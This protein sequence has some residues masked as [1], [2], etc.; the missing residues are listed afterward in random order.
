FSLAV[1]RLVDFWSHIRP[2]DVFRTDARTLA[3]VGMKWAADLTLGGWIGRH[4][5][6]SLLRS[7]P[8]RAVLEERLDMEAVH[9][10]IE[11][12]F[13][14]GLA[15]TTT[16]YRTNLGVTFFE[17][18]PEIAPWTRSTRFGIRQRLT[19]EHVMASSAIPIFFPAIRI[20]QRYYA[21][22]CL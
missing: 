16:D 9:E 22:G 1:R 8:L 13:L 11:R 17:G 5:E 18:A 19:I 4:R 2:D 7:D 3:K 21:D 20:G 14:H 10:N 12:G 6:K 15:L